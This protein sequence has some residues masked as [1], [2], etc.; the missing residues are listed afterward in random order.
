MANK[1]YFFHIA[2]FI[3]NPSYF[4]QQQVVFSTKNVYN[5]ETK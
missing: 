4:I 5:L 2:I 3:E 1:Q